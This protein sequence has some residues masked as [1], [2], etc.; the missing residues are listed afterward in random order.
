MP[1]NIFINE[2]HYDNASTDVGEFIEIAG[3]AGTDLSGWQIV[4]YNGS[5]GTT[6]N[7][8][9]L[10]GVIAD[11]SN[12]FGTV[13]V[14]YSTNGIQNGA[15]DGIAL[16]NNGTVVQFLSYEGSFIATNGVASG[17][18]S[19]NIGVN[20]SSSTPVGF[21]L[22]LTGTGSMD[23]D[24]TWTAPADD[25]PGAAN[26]GQI[27][28][29]GG[30][31]PS[32][33]VINE[34]HAD[35][36]SDLTG[37]ANGD[38]TRN[39]SQDE[40]IEI[41]NTTGGDVDISG[42]TLADG[43]G[44]RHTFP[45][46]TVVP[47]QGAI[48]VF[49]GGSPTG[50]FGNA[51][52]Q[53][54]S[55]GQLGLNNSGDTVTLN[56][57]TEDVATLTYGSEGGNNQSLTRDPDISGSV[58]QHST[59]TG[60]NG[61]LFSPGTEV[62]GD[63]FPGNDP[64]EPTLTRIY[65][66]QGEGHTSTLV[67]QAVTTT[68]I[69]T[70]VDSNGFY[71]QDATGDGNIATSDAL[72]VF[73][74]TAPGVSV[75]DE[76]RVK[77]TVSEFTPGG[78]STGNLSTTQIGGNPT[79][80]TLSTGNTLPGATIIGQ[81]GRVPPN[82]NIDDDAFT[83]FDP[84]NDGIDFFESLEGMRV[85]AQDVVAVSGT[86]RF[87]EIFG[88]VN[89]GAD[90]SGISDR[91]TLNISPNDFN[92]EKVQ[93]DADS[94][95]FDLDL[96]SVDVGAQ[97]GDVNGVVSYSFGNFEIIPTED[98]TSNVVASSL[99]QETTNLVGTVNQLTIASYNA[100]NLDPNENDGD[101]DIANGRFDAIARQILDNLQSP[102]IIAL[103]EI[104]DNSGSANDGTT[105]AD[106]TLQTLLDAI[107]LADDGL[108]NDSHSY[109]FID[110]A[111]I[112]NNASGGQPGGN[113]RTAFL[114]NR[115]RVNLVD[116]SVQPVGDQN[117]GSPFNGARL[118]LSATF[119]FNGQ[120]VTVV[121][122]HFSSKGGSAP[123]LGTSQDFAD[124]QEDP[125]VNGSLDERRVQ[126][127]A[128]N[129]FVDDIFADD[130]NANV[131]VL[132]DLNEF[133][134]VSPLQILEGTTVS[135][136]DGQTISDSDEA[137]VLTNLINQ[138]P[139][140][141]RYSFIFQGNSQ[142]LDHLLASNSLA[143]SAEIDTVHVNAEFAETNQ[144]ASD[145]DPVV[146]RFTLDVPDDVLI[147]T[148][149]GEKLKSKGQTTIYALGGN[150]KVTGSNKGD[151]IFGGEGNDFIK[152]DRVFWW[153]GDDTIFGGEG[154]DKIFGLAGDDDLFGGEGKDRIWGGF[155]D[156]LID[157]GE[158]KDTLFGGWGKDTFVIAEGQGTD[159]IRD[160]WVGKDFIGLAGGLTF[161]QLDIEQHRRNTLIQFED[162]TLAILKGVR[163]HRLTRDSFTP[164]V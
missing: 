157:G 97:L 102:D 161:G 7:T 67:G 36:A 70:A 134:F 120:E 73:T 164:V 149:K 74:G 133:E 95:V 88:V 129:N 90:A 112:E 52:A 66:I 132:G 105:A 59:A 29:G 19:T 93:I 44:V 119:T 63:P 152:G 48:V 154:N 146:A 144:R 139:E 75:G 130:A 121:N 6:Y 15:P 2:I 77:G 100:L 117:S 151:L 141:E 128:V 34:V 11:Q 145:H 4:L 37:D 101:T 28:G 14:N 125:S 155:G 108:A 122:N 16:V 53:T 46:G 113:I 20:E 65:E 96:P 18:T 47:N 148:D 163:A 94:G 41:V 87:G 45:S 153:G 123:I 72:F 40:F 50:T 107:D 35:P 126:A 98:F 127:Q 31:T 156:D 1:T 62:N 159:T 55:S 83:T 85:T 79:L 12:G 33:W 10:S 68:G 49:G 143:D 115:D 30:S 9:N 81:G 89:G 38:G 104:Q 43:F 23:T 61:A 71:L 25:T 116:G 64:P 5:N 60:S 3:P 99:E 80:T 57:G 42:W 124:R 82:Q 114:Y 109:E 138:I 111:F 27:F 76:L 110:N 8:Q 54:A 69:V 92:P 17:L 13:V 103:Q 91:G 160:F 118:P 58:V 106:L 51:I 136:A 26:N 150:D 56:N 140:D 21:S 135:S 84:V 147:G 158:G 78:T 22:Q 131:V 142:E 86:N 32:G 39:A 24:F 162:E 137:A